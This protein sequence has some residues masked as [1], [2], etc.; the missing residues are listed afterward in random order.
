MI[1]IDLQE[2]FSEV[3]AAGDDSGLDLLIGS[4]TVVQPPSSLNNTMDH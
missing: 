4:V 3:M 2:V 1:G